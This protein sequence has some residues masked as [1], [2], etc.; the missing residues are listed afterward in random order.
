MEM[1]EAYWESAK[2][3]HDRTGEWAY[4][5]LFNALDGDFLVAARG[6]RSGLDARAGEL[7]ALLRAGVDNAQRRFAGRRD[8]F[9]ALAEVE[10]HRIAALWACYDGRSE[11]CIAVPGVVNELLLH[12]RGVLQRL[13]STR[14]RDSVTNQLQF[15]IDMLPSDDRSN[16][17]KHAL[18]SLIE[19]IERELFD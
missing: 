13:G 8:F 6:E 15:V 3:A 18:R 19:G 2:F 4:Y 10:S 11:A 14:E 5:P 9:H 7:H 12:Y 17:I 1:R 16:R